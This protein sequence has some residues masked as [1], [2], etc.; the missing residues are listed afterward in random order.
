MKGLESKIKEAIRI[1]FN[2]RLKSI[3][4]FGS[5]I[6]MGYGRD[7]DILII[8]DR[9]KC[10]EEKFELEE[11]ATEI[12]NRLFKYNVPIDVHILGV[13][14]LDQNT[15]IGSFL[16]GLVL[17]YNVIY[18]ECN[19]ERKIEKMLEELAKLNYIYVNR[20]G[21]WNLSKLA[22]ITM[23]IKGKAKS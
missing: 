14:E 3:V 22:K 18:D 16:S 8:I 19:V 15:R 23:N 21:E 4:L 1:L 5:Y 7:L 2:D 6:Y 9:I 13:E 17:G 11:K 20:Y 10:L 12:L